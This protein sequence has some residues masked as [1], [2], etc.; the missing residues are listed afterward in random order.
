[1]PRKK[2]QDEWI[3]GREAADILTK[4]NGHEIRQNY[5]RWL[6]TN[7]KIAHRPR[8]GRTNEYLKADVE[9]VRI[10]KHSTAE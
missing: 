8:D 2:N 6:A 9:A 10:K 1:M 7:N 5:V 3:S 4:N